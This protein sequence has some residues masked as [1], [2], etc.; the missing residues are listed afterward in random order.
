VDRIDFSFTLVTATNLSMS[1]LNATIKLQNFGLIQ[2]GCG[3]AADLAALN[4][5]G[6]RKS[7]K[8]ITL[9]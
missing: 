7:F 5:V 8:K 1:M 2:F 3:A 4:L 6:F 9:N